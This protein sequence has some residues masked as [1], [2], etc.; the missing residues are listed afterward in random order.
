MSSSGA[1]GRLRSRQGRRAG[2]VGRYAQKRTGIAA[3]MLKKIATEVAQ[4]KSVCILW[5]MGVTQHCGG[6]DTSTSI[7]NLLLLTGNYMRPGTGAYPLRGHNNVQGASD[8]GSMPNTYP[9]YQPVEDEQIRKKFEA[10]WGV[11]LPPK[12]GLDNHEMVEAMEAPRLHAAG[13]EERKA[14][15]Q[16][17]DEGLTEERSGDGKPDRICAQA[18]GSHAGVAAAAGGGAE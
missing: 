2:P 15:S 16:Y 1:A 7:S 13:N 14:T 12:N 5:A 6:S 4:A 3:E 8:F 11:K 17:H 10:A 18:R 9:G